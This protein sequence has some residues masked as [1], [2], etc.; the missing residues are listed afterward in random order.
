MK[1][2]TLRN[3]KPRSSFLK[4]AEQAQACAKIGRQIV[5]FTMGPANARQTF[6]ASPNKPVAT[7]VWEWSKCPAGMMVKRASRKAKA[8]IPEAAV[9]S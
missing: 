5:R 6:V 8:V 9:V 7:L 2:I 3:I 4:V 1:T